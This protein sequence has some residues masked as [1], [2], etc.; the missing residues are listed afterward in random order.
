MGTSPEGCMKLATLLATALLA[1]AALSRMAGLP[2]RATVQEEDCIDPAIE[3]PVPCDE[4]D[5]D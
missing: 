2:A 3:Y 4:D 1:L 5:G